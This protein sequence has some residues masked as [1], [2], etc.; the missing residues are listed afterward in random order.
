MRATGLEPI[1]QL[2][3]YQSE[4]KLKYYIS[5]R[6]LATDYFIDFLPK[7]MHV[8]ELHTRASFI[9]E[10]SEGISSLQCL[11]APEFISHTK[12]IRLKITK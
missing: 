1:D 7:G 11:Y 6:D 10:F 12:G 9:G 8:I 3:G 5:Q 2:S 4:N